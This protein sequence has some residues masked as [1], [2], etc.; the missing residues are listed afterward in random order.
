MG[1]GNKLTAINQGL[2]SSEQS[3]TEQGDTFRD[4]VADL[5]RTRYPDTATE[6]RIAGTKVDITFSNYSLG[7][8]S[9]VAVECKDYAKPL[10][11]TYIAEKI[12]S[13]YDVMLTSGEIDQ[14]LI[15]SRVPISADAEALVKAWRGASHQ[16]YHQL[17][18][19]LL[20]L[21]HY[22]S[23]L[24]EIK[25]G[26]SEYVEA[27]F[28]TNKKT[29]FEVIQ[30][31]LNEARAPGIAILGGY[32]QGKTSFAKRLVAEQAKYYLDNPRNRLPI[33]L[34]LGEVIHETQLEGLFGKEFTARHQAPGYLFSTLEK[35][36]A[37]GRLLIVLDGFDEMKHAMT[38][39]D[40]RANFKEFNRLLVPNAKVVLLGRPSALPSEAR[41]LVFSGKMKVGDASVTSTAFQPWREEQL[42]FFNQSETE[43][44]LNAQLRQLIARYTESGQHTYP[45]D[46]FDSRKKDI[47]RK[48]PS[49]L[50]RRPVH[51][52][53]VAEL[54]VDPSFDFEGF[55]EFKLYQHFIR[56]MVNR[57][58]SEKASRR[59]IP[60]EPRLLFQRN[61]AWWAWTRPGST[62]G[63][64]LR[65][66]VPASLLENLADGG[67][68]D[69]EGKKSEYIVS[70]LT[71]E[72]ESGVLFFAHRSFQEFLVA[73]RALETKA[74]PN[75]HIEFAKYFNAE[76]LNFINQ[77]P[78]QSH[79]ED[80]YETLK[81]SDGPLSLAYLAF[82]ASSAQVRDWMLEEITDEQTGNMPSALIAIIFAAIDWEQADDTKL[83]DSRLLTEWLFEVV[84]SGGDL[85]SVWAVVALLA[86]HA[87]APMLNPLL[88][89]KLIA[90]ML[91]RCI[92]LARPTRND[93]ADLTIATQDEGFITQWIQSTPRRS[94]MADARII[95]FDPNQLLHQATLHV[96][97]AGF[98]LD[99]TAEGFAAQCFKNWFPGHQNML[100]SSISSHIP[101]D[102]RDAN[103]AFLHHNSLQFRLISVK[104]AH[105]RNYDKNV[106][107]QKQSKVIPRS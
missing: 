58:A 29:A 94:S 30:A 8:T 93:Q 14:V 102:L 59:Q 52:T 63:H 39:S 88:L 21:R 34:R 12:R 76:I 75:S 10:T 27:R 66:D 51:I 32:G 46:F 73:E 33:L 35:L 99:S 82:F 55:N 19:S 57:D 65:E 79:L 74:S 4:L 47:H 67:S 90:K 64:F 11:K 72:K 56:S 96:H 48:V 78:D 100:L 71:E 20:G 15:V 84:V 70:T 31:W 77:S 2:V 106:W 81:S 24:A 28:D 83:T 13:V 37:L 98:L 1:K 23:T 89:E 40:F 92:S 62:Q 60:I 86:K 49:D 68:S 105:Q 22:V 80:W 38:S 50:L 9:K 69:Y 3:T 41:N 25:T 16:T 5:L 91:Q 36:N 43:T 45:I 54:A 7:R 26:D 87:M 6:Q 17:A 44:L 103:K 104:V 95:W 61:L 85:A 107:L 18:E 97:R 101:T 42:A 53:L